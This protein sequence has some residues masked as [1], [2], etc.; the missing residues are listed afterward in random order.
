M[1]IDYMAD[2][3]VPYFSSN[4]QD[5]TAYQ[6]PGDFDLPPN[7]GALT[8]ATAAIFD[9]GNSYQV[10]DILTVAGGVFSTPATLRVT[11]IGEGNVTVIAVEDAGNYTTAPTNHVEVSGGNGSGALFDLTW[12]GYPPQRL[13]TFIEIM[14]AYI[15]EIT[16][17]HEAKLVQD[18]L[19]RT[20]ATMRFGSVAW[21]QTTMSDN[22]QF[23]AMRYVAHHRLATDL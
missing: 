3:V 13:L 23:K 22:A 6:I 17:V 10:N 14:R 19:G 15:D 9:G 7:F 21:D 5:E 18:I 1:A 8:V 20:M 12:D 2:I 4:V 16:N 11:E